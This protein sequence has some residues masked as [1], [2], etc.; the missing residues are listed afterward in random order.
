MLRFVICDD[1]I[2]VLNKLSHMIETVFTKNDLKAEIVFKT[3]KYTELYSY[4]NQ[5][6]IDVLVLDIHL[7][8]KLNGI[9]I[10]NQIRKQNKDCYIIFT[11]AHPEYVF[12]AYKCKTFDYLCKPI[13]KERIEESILRLFDDIQGTQFN[14]KYIKLDNKNTII[15]QNEIQYIKRDGMQVV[16][17]TDSKDYK[18]YSSFN[19]IKDRL[20]KNFIRCHKS[21][22]ANINNIQKLEPSSNLIYFTNN[23]TCDIGPKYKDNLINELEESKNVK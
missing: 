8:S 14:N 16:F 23:S 7:N 22:I 3:T 10:A 21:F 2:N 6:Q 18:T 17:H 11:T 15:N 20:P 13:T 19:K 1:N 9:D 4:I 12:L 5:N